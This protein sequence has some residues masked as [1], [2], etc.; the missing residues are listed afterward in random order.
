MQISSSN[1]PSISWPDSHIGYPN[2]IYCKLA[3]TS[4][5]RLIF[6][7]IYTHP[8]GDSDCTTSLLGPGVVPGHSA[9]ERMKDS[10]YRIPLRSLHEKTRRSPG[11]YPSGVIPSRPHPHGGTHPVR[12]PAQ[13]RSDIIPKSL[14]TA[15]GERFYQPIGPYASNPLLLHDIQPCPRTQLYRHSLYIGRR[16]GGPLAICSVFSRL[17]AG[18]EHFSCPLQILGCGDLDVFAS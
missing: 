14:R 12:C 17:E 9:R 4:L 13:S 5:R 2:L 11:D 16:R 3:L 6:F 7:F 10:K 8:S 1:P 15:I 18:Q